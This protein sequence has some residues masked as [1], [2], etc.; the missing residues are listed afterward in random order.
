MGLRR[1]AQE[2]LHYLL[3][4]RVFCRVIL[5]HDG[6]NIMKSKPLLECFAKVEWAKA[7]IDKLISRINALTATPRFN[8]PRRPSTRA[9]PTPAYPGL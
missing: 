9:W 5:D 7:E 3:E 4:L 8:L 6:I 1:R 2:S